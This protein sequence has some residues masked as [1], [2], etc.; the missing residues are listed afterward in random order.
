[1]LVINL[2]VLVMELVIVERIIDVVNMTNHTFVINAK[3]IVGK[4]A[5]CVKEQVKQDSLMNITMAYE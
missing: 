2:A 1:M 4:N 5:I 3:V